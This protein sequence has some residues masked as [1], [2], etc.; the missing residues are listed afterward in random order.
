[1]LLFYTPTCGSFIF[2]D[3]TVLDTYLFCHHKPYF[4]YGNHCVKTLEALPL[5]NV[6]SAYAS[7][8]LSS[9]QLE[10]L[11]LTYLNVKTFFQGTISKCCPFHIVMM[12]NHS[13][14]W[15]IQWIIWYCIICIVVSL[16]MS[17]YNLPCSVS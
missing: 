8:S 7:P 14:Q 4:L 15:H 11:F 17:C 1:M 2:T 6:Q 13:L 3:V 12:Y 5:R 10:A 16:R 9:I